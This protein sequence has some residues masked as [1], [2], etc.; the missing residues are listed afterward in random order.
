MI[1]LPDPA[2]RILLV[3]DNALDRAEAKA[4]LIL[5]SPR[6]YQFT[7][8]STVAQTITLC[9]SLPLFDCVLLDFALTDGDALDVL[10]A[11]ARDAHQVPL[12]PVVII[13]GDASG[14]T[15]RAALRAGAQDHLG[16][17]WLGAESLTRAVENAVERHAMSREINALR[18]L[19]QLI[20]AQR[21][22][23]LDAERAARLEGER[24]ALIK[25]E[26]LATLS[27]ELRTPLAAI[28]G[29]AGVLKRSQ[30]D[31]EVVRR[32]VDAI[33]RN[34]AAQARLIDD[35]LDMN[36]IVSGKLKMD[37]ELLDA[38]VVCHLAVDTLRPTAEAK[39]VRLTL[40]LGDNRRYLIRSDATR[41]QQ[42]ITNLLGNA[43]KFTPK[44]GTVSLT[45][46]ALPSAMVRFCVRDNGVGI[47]PKFLPFLFDRF[48]QANGSASRA[49]GGLGLGLSIVKQ[50]VALH[51]GWV[52]AHSD[53]VGHGASFTMLLP[54]AEPRTQTSA[55][56]QTQAMTV[57]PTTAPAPLA[58]ATQA[59][60]RDELGGLLVL[61]VDDQE[62]VL[63]LCRRLLVDSGALVQTA[64]SGS[65][66]LVVLREQTPDVLVSDIG[67]PDMDGYQFLAHVRDELK[68][69]AQRLPAVALSA[70]T[71]PVDHARAMQAGFGAYVDKPIV[72]NRLLRA[73]LDV[74]LASHAASARAI[75]RTG[76]GC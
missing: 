8:A 38:E 58:S 71:R 44:G 11:I 49:H 13:T 15:S 18:A 52:S 30:A 53:G 3:D 36:R 47:D 14:H 51:N 16:K 20:E 19:G 75:D 69:T 29:W 59:D 56:L 40:K 73:V 48:S 34:G 31:A 67:M 46:D 68:L 66:A 65:A 6:R 21:E 12:L 43:V 72:P 17:A 4:A 42:I 54:C 63:E 25:D 60:P 23:W 27:H 55:P 41:L 22:Q 33:A 39:G 5:G 62:D 10:A 37:M 76:V 26:F 32:G 74:R 1:D 28:V 57:Q 2:W 70:F 50:L 24:V 64:A 7:E 35:L 9:A 61:L 45:V